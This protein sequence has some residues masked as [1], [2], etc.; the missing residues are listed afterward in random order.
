[1]TAPAQNVALGLAFRNKPPEPVAIA[2]EDRSGAEVL[3]DALEQDADFKSSILNPEQAAIRSKPQARVAPIFAWS[4]HAVLG[5]IMSGVVVPTTMKSMSSGVRPACLIAFSEASR[6]A[7]G[8][9]DTP[10]RSPGS[11]G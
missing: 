3:H 6:A 7:A 10:G 4:R 1:M 8:A 2:I 9:W 11:A 5:K